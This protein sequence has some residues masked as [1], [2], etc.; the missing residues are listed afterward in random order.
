MRHSILA[1][2]LSILDDIIEPDHDRTYNKTCATSE[3]SDQP[4]HPHVPYKI[5]GLPKE[6]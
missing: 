5:S 3:D 6:G 2:L 4:V 1:E